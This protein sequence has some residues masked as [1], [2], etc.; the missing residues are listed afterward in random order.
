MVGTSAGR[1]QVH[2][3]QGTLLQRQRLHTRPVVAL[4]VRR[5]PLSSV[6]PVLGHR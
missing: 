6:D 1:L 2:S 4:R 5:G 3:L